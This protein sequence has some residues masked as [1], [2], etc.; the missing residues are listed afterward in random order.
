MSS[1]FFYRKKPL[2]VSGPPISLL[3][4]VVIY[5]FYGN[6]GC[7][8][9]GGSLRLAC[10]IAPSISTYGALVVKASGPSSLKVST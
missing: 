10:L 6:P 8:V 1:M 7:F 9:L 3:I 5:L 2:G 4:T